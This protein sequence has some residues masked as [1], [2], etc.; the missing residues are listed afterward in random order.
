M[1]WP[2]LIFLSLLAASSTIAQVVVDFGAVEV[3]HDSVMVAGFGNP[4]NVVVTITLD[5]PPTPFYLVSYRHDST[6]QWS[7]I[8][9]F[10]FHPDSAGVFTCMPARCMDANGNPTGDYLR[11]TGE[12]VLPERARDDF[13]LYPSS[14]GL[15]AYPN[16]FNPTTEIRYSLAAPGQASIVI[17]DLQG[18]V[19]H[20]FE[21]NEVAIGDHSV[22]FNADG[23]ASGV[24]FAQLLSGSQMVTQKLLLVK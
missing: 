10:R 15:S 4:D 11:L 2:Y 17:Y 24:Y 5:V 7:Y 14:F 22:R 13:D 12:G 19:V 9:Q 3:G 20:R 18:R 16:P 21:M 8:F 6:H 1:K 23:L